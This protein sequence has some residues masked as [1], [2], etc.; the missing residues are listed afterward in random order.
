M[1]EAETSLQEFVEPRQKNK[2]KSLHL[3]MECRNLWGELTNEEKTTLKTLIIDAAS[4][5][6][7][8]L[9]LFQREISGLKTSNDSRNLIKSI[10]LK[11]YS[12]SSDDA[13]PMLLAE[14]VYRPMAMFIK[15]IT[16]TNIAKDSSLV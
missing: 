7:L 13:L 4:E 8:R 10:F 11:L 15:K 2:E 1:S 5:K 14:T 6:S 3:I 12:K 16:D 9:T